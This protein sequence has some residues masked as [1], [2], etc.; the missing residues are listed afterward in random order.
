MN[1]YLES[2][3][4]SLENKDTIEQLVMN[5]CP[6]LNYDSDSQI[7]HELSPP[8]FS[9]KGYV[10]AKRKDRR[11][12]KQLLLE[13]IDNSLEVI[14]L[15]KMGGNITIEFIVKNSIIQK[16]IITDTSESGTGI[17]DLTKMF[18]PYRHVGDESGWSECGIG[19]TQSLISICNNIK[20]ITKHDS[21]TELKILHI[22][23]NDIIMDDKLE[24]DIFSKKN[25]KFINTSGT[26]IIIQN[27][28]K[29]YNKF[30]DENF[31]DL[32]DES[33]Y[34]KTP[35]NVNIYFKLSHLL[36]KNK[37]NDKVIKY[38]DFNI[39]T[40]CFNNPDKM[41]IITF[42]VYENTNESLECYI[43]DSNTHYLK[44]YY[45]DHQN[46]NFKSP[47]I[48]KSIASTNIEMKEVCE[49]KVTYLTSKT[50]YDNNIE[51]SYMGFHGHR[52]VTGGIRKSTINPL[53]LQWSTI[54]KH[55]TRYSKFRAVIDYT[56]SADVTFGSNE[57]KTLS[58]ERLIYY[59]VRWCILKEADTYIKHMRTRYNEYTT[60]PKQNSVI[61]FMKPNIVDIVQQLSNIKAAAN[62]IIK[63]MDNLEFTLIPQCYMFYYKLNNSLSDGT[64]FINNK[65]ERKNKYKGLLQ[66]SS[67]FL[68]E[69]EIGYTNNSIQVRH[70][71]ANIQFVQY[72]NNETSKRG[73]GSSKIIA[74]IKV[75][76]KLK[77]LDYIQFGNH[78]SPQSKEKFRFPY[79]KIQE[80]RCIIEDT[81][82]TCRSSQGPF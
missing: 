74:E 64:I 41:K 3:N 55:I 42:K 58:D 53:K 39:K 25:N 31:D 22:D 61:T 16:I 65:R 56:Q 14:R 54:T 68:I 43:Y 44:T 1:S 60:S 76:E 40:K 47:N 82:Y 78:E 67:N 18:R 26:E 6:P 7:V 5:K 38:E 51:R 79:K 48:I 71:Q 10:E 73:H 52:K 75:I 37:V 13:L 23:I 29:N 32:N 15:S 4:Y 77:E 35:D 9:W 45:N 69:G 46:D 27:L 12:L 20:I 59:S 28:N 63:E 17:K 11:P 57:L 62:K 21:D 81:I 19:G 36:D 24:K 33:L 34:V 80:V 72:I 70:P 2:S 50:N 8:D 30:S 66:V 49:F